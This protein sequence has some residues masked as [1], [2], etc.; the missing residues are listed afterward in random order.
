MLHPARQ[1]QFETQIGH[2]LINLT[3]LTFTAEDIDLLNKGLSFSPSPTKHSVA[4]LWLDFKR[5]ERSLLL[6]H[7]FHNSPPKE[8]YPLYSFKEKSDWKPYPGPI[9]IQQLTRSFNPLAAMADQ[10]PCAEPIYC[11]LILN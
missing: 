8:M 9:E 4:D 1:D 11:Y 2:V 3:D 7:H 10:F 5:F 6:K